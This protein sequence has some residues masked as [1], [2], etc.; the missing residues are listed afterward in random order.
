[1]MMCSHLLIIKNVD[2]FASTFIYSVFFVILS[3]NLKLRFNCREKNKEL[4]VRTKKP[5]YSDLFMS[6][7][8]F[9][10]EFHQLPLHCCFFQFNTFFP[11]LVMTS[12]IHQHVT[13]NALT[14]KRVIKLDIT[15]VNYDAIYLCVHT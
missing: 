7:L 15:A 10:F 11:C 12:K 5:I 14:H 6:N 9:S 8:P 4:R 1:M 3:C 13:I 2:R